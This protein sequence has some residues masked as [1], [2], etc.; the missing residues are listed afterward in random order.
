[1]SKTGE[2]S[3]FSVAELEGAFLRDSGHFSDE[4][5]PLVLN[6]N[7]ASG[8]Q[9]STV[10]SDFAKNSRRER[11]RV[12]WSR[13]RAAREL[14]SRYQDDTKLGKH[15]TK[16]CM[17]V[18]IGYV[19]EHWKVG[20]DR[21]FFK[22][23]VICGSRCACPV[24][25]EKIWAWDRD[26][27]QTALSRISKKGL[28]TVMVTYTLR[29]NKFMSCAESLDKLNKATRAVKSGRAWQDIKTQYGF[30]GSIT[31]WENTWSE[32]SGHHPHKHSVEVTTD[33]LSDVELQKLEKR[34][35][36]LYLKALTKVGASGEYG[37]AVNVRRADDYAAEYIAKVGHEP[38]AK[39]WGASN[40]LTSYQA[41]TKGNESGHYSMM[42]L[43][44]L[45][46]AGDDG[47]GAAWL[48]YV[49]AF[50]GRAMVAW[51]KGLRVKLGMSEQELSEQEKAERD[52]MGKVFACYP[53]DEWKKV[54]TR[55]HD[56][57]EASL[58][59]GWDAFIEYL[60][61]K[62]IDAEKPLPASVEWNEQGII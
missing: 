8:G 4:V 35:S 3:G 23:V 37:V 14:L 44:D 18:N 55:P 7:F 51:S 38:Q 28:Y 21:A 11:D 53:V 31:V 30:I 2:L 45:W 39:K 26:E 22:S 58:D 49:E 61:A 59:M 32:A 47:A 62:G 48:N 13:L 10:L 6:T 17:W 57:L 43:L 60:K 33:N 36:D 34:I 40:E 46:R 1:M 12:K 20:V 54:R 29:H 41:K 42:Q 9:F 50:T 56:I 27:I 24:C 25:S 19:V 5:A 15:R 52:D 16:K